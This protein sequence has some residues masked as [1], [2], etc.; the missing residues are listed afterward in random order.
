ML[1]RVEASNL[2]KTFRSFKRK[3]GLWGAVQDLFSREYI[4]LRAVDGVSFTLQPGEMVGYIGPNGAGKSTSVKMLTGILVPTSGSVTAN[5]YVP[6]RDRS[7]YTHTIGVV[8]GQRTQLWWDIAVV[9][10]FRLLKEIYQV[11]DADYRARMAHF[12]DILELKR[13]LHQPV[14]KL[15]LGERMRCDMAAALIHNPPLLFLDEP[16]IGLDLLAKESI[17]QFLKEVN[18]NFGTTVL[19]TTH[20]LADIEELCRRLMIIDHGRILFD[21]PL[22]EL[23]RM[24][25]RQNQ[26][27]F[28]LKDREQGGLFDALDLPRIARERLDDLTYRLSFDREDYTCGDVIRRVVATIDV[29]DIFIDEESIEGIVRRIYT[30][31]VTP[32]LQKR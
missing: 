22:G 20:D 12:D 24:L 13:Y 26:I 4:S 17:R 25:W 16:T 7:A 18:R 14:R 23:K 8:F 3:E 30:G 21:G 27:K 11:S 19:L 28:E 6:Y 32:E 5:G 29:R 9:E 31:K 2:I 1:G 10:S 15:S